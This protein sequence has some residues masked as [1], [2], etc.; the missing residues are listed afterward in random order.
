MAATAG[1]FATLA[2]VPHPLAA[3]RN[4]DLW[5]YRLLGAIVPNFDDLPTL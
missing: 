2:H 1:D 4:G 5:R 3:P